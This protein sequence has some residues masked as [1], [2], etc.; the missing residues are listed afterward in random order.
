[1]DTCRLS[2]N[3]NG[4]FWHPLGD[5]TPI[6]C[7]YGETINSCDLP[8]RQLAVI[9]RE[10]FVSY[11]S[12]KNPRAVVVWNVAG[13]GLQT[14]P[15]EEEAKA[16]AARMLFVGTTGDETIPTGWQLLRPAIPGQ[17]QGGSTTLWLAPG[18]RVV[19]RPAFTGA[20]VPVRVLVIPGDD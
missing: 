8:H 19:L 14:Q 11:G 16:I 9:E 7:R 12:L 1:M 5:Q 4:A 20:R 10:T 2:I 6:D 15:T 17:D 3:A 18:T 13:L